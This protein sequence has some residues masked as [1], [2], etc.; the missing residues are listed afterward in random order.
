MA[1]RKSDDEALTTALDRAE[2]TRAGGRGGGVSV[3]HGEVLIRGK[4]QIPLSPIEEKSLASKYPINCRRV[5]VICA[6]A[7]SP[8]INGNAA[9]SAKVEWGNFVARV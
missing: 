2:L 5:R 1:P 6:N 9:P 3:T 7:R 8:A 4:T